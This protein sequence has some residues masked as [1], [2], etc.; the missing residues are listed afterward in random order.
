METDALLI[1]V[2]SFLAWQFDKAGVW[3]I[4]SGLLRYAFVAAA[5]IFTWMRRP[6]PPSWRRKAV[7]AIQTIALVTAI[8]PIV[9]APLSKTICAVSLILLAWSFL[10]D[11][12]WLKRH[13]SDAPAVN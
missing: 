4:A 1:L 2:L 7:A 11:S 5:W 6:L 10:I 9:P 13:A 3:V 12:V 8:A